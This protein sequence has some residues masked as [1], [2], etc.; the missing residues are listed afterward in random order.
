MDNLPRLTINLKLIEEQ[1]E[2][3]EIEE[4]VDQLIL[5]TIHYHLF[6]DLTPLAT[7]PV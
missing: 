1:E 7:L 2:Q 5:E 6:Q 4:I 3:E